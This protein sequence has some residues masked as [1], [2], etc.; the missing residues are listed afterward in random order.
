MPDSISTTLR[1]WNLAKTPSATRLPTWLA[2]PCAWWMWSSARKEGKAALC[3]RVAV[4][5]AGMDG[6]R[7][8]RV[9]RRPFVDRPVGAPSKRHFAHGQ[10]Q[11]LDEALVAG[12]T[13][14]LGH[15]LFRVLEGHE[16][17]APQALVPG[18]PI[19]RQPAIG[20]RTERGREIG[21][22]DGMD[23]GDER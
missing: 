17:R 6:E 9:S 22:V 2:K 13:L 4:G 11:D 3:Q 21:V 20:R 7:R 16:K 23:A 19:P 12:M 8:N 18:K 10:R 1:S 14:D 15:R 5:A